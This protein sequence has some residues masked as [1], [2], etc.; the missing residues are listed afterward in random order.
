MLQL[1]YQ[2]NPRKGSLL[3]LFLVFY[4]ASL[5]LGA[6]SKS[7]CFWPHAY[8]MRMF[9]YIVSYFECLSEHITAAFSFLNTKRRVITREI[10]Q[11]RYRYIFIITLECMVAIHYKC[12][13]LHDRECLCPFRLVCQLQ[14]LSSKVRT[15]R[16]VPSLPQKW[17]TMTSCVS[18]CLGLAISRGECHNNILFGLPLPQGQKMIASSFQPAIKPGWRFGY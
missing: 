6:P 16:F 8:K 17:I 14:P 4:A 9:V 10:S 15:L 1:C 13:N 12:R 2:Y 3:L 18:H 7:D 11:E 5:R